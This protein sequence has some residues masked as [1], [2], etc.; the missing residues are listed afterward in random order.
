MQPRSKRQAQR[1]THTQRAHLRTGCDTRTSNRYGQAQHRHGS[2]ASSMG[3]AGATTRVGGLYRA[4]R[5]GTCEQRTRQT[6]VTQLAGTGTH[7]QQGATPRRHQQHLRAT[8]TQP[9]QRN[10]VL[11]DKNPRASNRTPGHHSREQRHVLQ[12]CAKS[13]SMQAAGTA[14]PRQADTDARAQMRD[15]P[16]TSNNGNHATPRWALAQFTK[17]LFTTQAT[18]DRSARKPVPDA[19]PGAG[20]VRRQP[21]RGPAQRSKCLQTRRQ[22]LPNSVG[23]KRVP[24]T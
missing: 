21:T 5:C 23:G 17:G 10:H 8:R 2:T 11:G 24:T 12:R 19:I 16:P 18:G 20:K 15:A 14:A 9:V 1:G 6:L 22:A 7:L 3:T 13:R 4:T